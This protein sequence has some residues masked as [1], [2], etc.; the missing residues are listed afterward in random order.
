MVTIGNHTL[1]R[2]GTCAKCSTS[3]FNWTGYCVGNKP[4]TLASPAY[5]NMRLPTNEITIEAWVKIPANV[6]SSNN[7]LSFYSGMGELIHEAQTGF[8]LGFH[9]NFPVFGVALTN[10]THQGKMIWTQATT[11]VTGPPLSLWRPDRWYHMA[12]SWDGTYKRLYIDGELME[13]YRP[14]D[15]GTGI[16]YGDSKFTIGGAV[17]CYTTVSGSLAEIRLWNVGRTE[18][19]IRDWMSQ[20][21]SP[22]EPGLIGLWRQVNGSQVIDETGNQPP[23]TIV[24]G[25][26]NDPSVTFPP[27]QDSGPKWVESPRCI[28]PPTNL[29]GKF[30]T[31]PV[32]DLR[33][34]ADYTTGVD[35][36]GRFL[37][38]SSAGCQNPITRQ[39]CSQYYPKCSQKN[40]TWTPRWDGV[41]SPPPSPYF[42]ENMSVPLPVCLDTCD[43]V[44]TSCKLELS[45]A[46]STGLMPLMYQVVFKSGSVYGGPPCEKVVRDPYHFNTS[47]YHYPSDNDTTNAFGVLEFAFDCA[48]DYANSTLD[49]SEIVACGWPTVR[50]VGE[51]DLTLLESVVLYTNTNSTELNVG[52]FLESSN[53]VPRCPPAV[54]WTE[55]Y[56]ALT[57]MGSITSL[58][59]FVCSFAC[60]IFLLTVPAQ[61][62]FPGLLLTLC[63]ICVCGLSF[64]FLLSWFGNYTDYFCLNGLNK[65]AEQG[66][67]MLC[68]AQA[69]LIQFFALNVVLYWGTMTFYLWRVLKMQVPDS[70]LGPLFLLGPALLSAA[71]VAVV[72]G[73]NNLGLAITGNFCWIRASALEVSWGTFYAPVFV[74]AGFNLFILI[75]YARTKVDFSIQDAA[76]SRMWK[77]AFV[78]FLVFGVSLAS[79][80][81]ISVQYPTFLSNANALMQCQVL[82]AAYD[83]M[84]LTGQSPAGLRMEKLRLG[85]GFTVLADNKADFTSCPPFES[86]FSDGFLFFD[87]FLFHSLGLFLVVIFYTALVRRCC[88]KGLQRMSSRTGGGGGSSGDKGSRDSHN[89]GSTTGEKSSRIRMMKHKN[90][91]SSTELSQA[92]ELGG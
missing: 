8:R 54:F 23:G 78:L 41:L 59:A 89:N 12:G 76:F 39:L 27:P 71:S 26:T 9:E 16:H 73:T 83:L 61:R 11:A 13:S 60:V 38:L 68:D 15:P 51:Q 85:G 10:E 36:F 3:E 56:E 92:Q 52:S 67:N 82:A 25:V 45:I 28:A 40:V 18:T 5:E 33:P 21:V 43:E 44:L 31:Y 79:Q 34:L 30:V 70:R 14:D 29:C 4:V 84:L 77:M 88:K 37:A 63:V 22:S 19:Q 2:N 72:A 74:I 86:G 81:H 66:D 17:D 64:S 20:L 24:G 75:S 80:L 55:T 50:R 90:A 62:R 69:I 1:E 35:T 6:N 58:V 32:Y 87:Q 57:L 65:S 7:F 42:F 53:C 48:I 46:N 49:P 91:L 47:S